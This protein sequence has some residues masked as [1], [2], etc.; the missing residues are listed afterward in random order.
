MCG[1]HFA[2]G[3]PISR[4][5]K[6]ARWVHVVRGGLPRCDRPHLEGLPRQHAGPA[7]DRGKS[8][9]WHAESVTVLTQLSFY[10]GCQACPDLALQELSCGGYEQK[11]EKCD[12]DLSGQY[13]A[14]MVSSKELLH[15]SSLSPPKE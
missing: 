12:F 1:Q 8:L 9:S 3:T 13:L 4:R 5:R 15:H 6:A 2:G 11:V 7:A 14:S 10:A